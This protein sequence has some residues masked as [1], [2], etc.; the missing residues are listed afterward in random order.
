MFENW[1][2]RA[3]DAEDRVRVLEHR[4]DQLVDL[5]M[6]P[7]TTILP[8]VVPPEMPVRQDLPPSLREM[9]QQRTRPGTNARKQ[10]LAFAMEAVMSGA[11]LAEVE[12]R[13]TMGDAADYDE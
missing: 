9:I 3:L 7:I 4:N 10:L 8:P 11:D 1:K 13:I 12:A 6:K 5:L 2:Q